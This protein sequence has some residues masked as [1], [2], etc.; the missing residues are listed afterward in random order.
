MLYFF[1]EWWQEKCKCI[2]HRCSWGRTR[3][4]TVLETDWEP[5]HSRKLQQGLFRHHTIH[6]DL[7]WYLASLHCFLDL[8]GIVFTP[9]KWTEVLCKSK[10]ALLNMSSNTKEPNNET[11]QL[12]NPRGSVGRRGRCH[13]QTALGIRH[14]IKQGPAKLF[15]EG[16]E[17][18]YVRLRGHTVSAT[19]TMS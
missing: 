2:W 18:K 1:R 10:T 4:S 13:P 12:S 7:T 6:L 9:L 14:W 16:T 17:S 3:W 8:S 5:R 19:A 11:W 15:C